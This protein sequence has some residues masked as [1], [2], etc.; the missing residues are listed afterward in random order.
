MKRF[1]SCILVFA[2]ILSVSSCSS[3]S[4]GRSA[5]GMNDDDDDDSE[6]S[7]DKNRSQEDEEEDSAVPADYAPDFSFTT[8]DRDGV[9]YDESIF[10]DYELTMINF[11][12]QWC[13]PC[14][15]EIPELERL[16]E[17]YSGRGFTVLGVYETEDMES[18]VDEILDAAAVDYP[19]LHYT[20][21]FDQFKT[22]YV[23]TT[24]FVDGDGHV[25]TLDSGEQSVIGA[26]D[27]ESWSDII[28]DLLHR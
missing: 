22:G 11:W 7:L 26:L 12:E 17:D 13:G 14:V 21:E 19:I 16:Y 6:W 23:P 27:Y 24:I 9:Q 28:E 20:S 8:V 18:D 10:A 15:S 3:S 5:R 1:L 25:I 2:L 4:N